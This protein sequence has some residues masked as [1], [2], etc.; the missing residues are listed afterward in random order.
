[1]KTKFFTALMLFI[2]IGAAGV[3]AA[4]PAAPESGTIFGRVTDLDDNPLPGAS[5]ALTGPALM[6]MYSNVTSATGQFFFPVLAPGT[7][8]IRIEMPGFKI[9]VQRGLSVQSGRAMQLHVRLEETAVDEE[10]TAPA[11]DQPVD[12]RNTKTSAVFNSEILARLPLPRDLFHLWPLVPGAVA[13]VARD[14]RFVSVEGSA[15]QNQIV[16]LEG[17]MMNDPVT[18]LPLFHPI[19]E[20]VEEVEYV[21]SGQPAAVGSA[22]GAYLQVVAKSGGNAFAGGLSY[23]STGASLAQDLDASST[24]T[25][26]VQTPERYE[27]YRDLSFNLGGSLMDDRAWVFLAGRR[28]T[29]TI[30]NPYDPETRMA[31]LGFTDSPAFDLS[32]REWTG[33]AKLSVRPTNDITYSGLILFNNFSE[34]YDI[35]SVFA[36]TAA[37]RVP[38]RNPEN[39]LATTH[40]F[41]YFLGQ[42]TVAELQAAYIHHRSVLASRADKGAAAVYDA[43][44]RI[45]WGAPAYEGTE[46]S[47]SF[48]GS[49]SLT[50]FKEDLFGLDHEVKIGAEYNQAEAHND[51]HR[52]NPFNTYWYDYAEGNPY[53]YD[54]LS[55]G[56]LEII[57]APAAA[58]SWDVSEMTRKMAVFFQDTLTRKRLA[59]NVGLR[60]D[61]QV[62]SYP[63]QAR[64]LTN[65][66]YAPEFL[67][68]ALDKAAFRDAIKTIIKDAGVTSPL[69]DITAAERTSVS[70]LT[71]SPRAGLV[72]D[73][74]GNGR[75]ALKLSYARSHEPLWIS[76]YDEDQI[77]E[78]QTLSF[79]WHDFNANKLMDMPGTDDYTLLSWRSQNLNSSYYA[80]VKSPLTDEFTGGLEYGAA[81]NL[82]LGLKFTYRKTANIVESVDSVNGYDP[83]AADEIGRIWL[84]MTVTDPG[85]D[86]MFGTFDDASLTVYGLRADRPAP[87][88]AAA[89][90]EGAYRKY[91]SATLTLDKR[92]ANNWQ[93]RGSFTVSSL[94]GTSDF[95]AAGRL[96]RTTLFNDPNSLTHTEGPLAYDR[97]IQAKLSGTYLFPFNV[98]FS[99]FFQ[100][101]SGAPWARTITV[102]FP[103]GYMG[104]GTREPSV[105]VFA[106]P[107]GTNRAPA[108]ACLDLHLEK[109]FN[110]KKGAQLS[111]M[112]DV[113]NATGRN[114]QTIVK[115]PAGI[116]D[117]RK[118]PATYTVPSVYGR[119]VNLY[120]V[121]QFRIGVKL[122]I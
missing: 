119:T 93:L 52:A 91:L 20:A 105:T 42:N 120:G 80:N 71:L 37:D 79:I 73:L 3:T 67:N 86:G 45:W 102:Y 41:H 59:V 44:Q 6:G 111:V 10:V 83:L 88:W 63:L 82:L 87:V 89:N 56:R 2:F 64:A 85:S 106:E 17:A 29:S 46:E 16:K 38:E 117:E 97:P 116:L 61:Y 36:D 107:W 74:L 118:T 7:Y 75:A 57:P 94:R 50:H 72:I 114:T 62:L 5:V 101:Y 122:G 34:P 47:E 27:R 26:R 103:A 49:V 13:D 108:V 4:G 112:V 121:R 104:Y 39:I 11:G 113:F 14:R 22:D 81:P 25:L 76:G 31:A 60:A 19:D 58:E 84:P 43:A 55:L 99:A 21:T 110:L 66:G 32:R 28:L 65:P 48:G 109:S 100:Y 15:P 53:Y 51:W 90:P 69:S 40:N 1:M 24:G 33:F 23:Y 35:S 54:G 30:S 9:Q 12:T 70:F 8:E 18:G 77:F 96:N 78:P 92:M 115:D 95:A 98:S 68:P